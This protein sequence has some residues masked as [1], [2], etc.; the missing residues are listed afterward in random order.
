MGRI[1]SIDPYIKYVFL[2]ARW[3]DAQV[4]RFV[5]ADPWEGSIQQPGTLHKYAY[6]QNNTPN[7]TDP[8]GMWR[9][10]GWNVSMILRQLLFE[11][12]EYERQAKSDPHDSLKVTHLDR[13]CHNATVEK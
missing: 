6:V 9:W 1:A 5:S 12:R 10:W 4:G 8:T 11:Y 7:Y 2:R 13:L 3:Y